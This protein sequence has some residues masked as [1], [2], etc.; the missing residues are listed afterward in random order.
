[1]LTSV[2]L[3][4][5]EDIRFTPRNRHSRLQTRHCEWT[6]TLA[7]QEAADPRMHVCGFSSWRRISA[8]RVG[9]LQGALLGRSGVPAGCRSHL[10]W[11]DQLLRI[12]QP[13]SVT[14]S[15]FRGYIP[16]VAS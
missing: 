2:N 8:A 12:G 3:P 7:D 10:L 4:T 5:S 9:A 14:L 1:M 13:S 15:L 6:G 16:G 11:E